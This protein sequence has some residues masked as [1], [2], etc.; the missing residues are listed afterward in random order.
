MPRVNT[1]NVAVAYTIESALGVC[2]NFDWRLLEP[3]SIADFGATISTVARDPISRDRQ[4]RKGSIT[5]L[6]SAVG[7]ESDLTMASASA[8][9]SR[10]S[11][12]R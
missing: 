4:R 7:L 5:D 11:A 6:D 3:N 12:L 1:N 2:R 8:T 10:A 9:S